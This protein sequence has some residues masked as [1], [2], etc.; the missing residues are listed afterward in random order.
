M[1]KTSKLGVG[2]IAFGQSGRGYTV[3]EVQNDAVILSHPQEEGAKRV[4]IQKI[5]RWEYPHERSDQMNI[6]QQPFQ[7]GD[8]V[9]VFVQDF[10]QPIRGKWC[11]GVILK[12]PIQSPDPQ[13]NMGCWKVTLQEGQTIRYCWHPLYLFSL[14]HEHGEWSL[15]DTSNPDDCK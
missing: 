10:E 11:S 7:V 4:L 12:T 14:N 6:Y 2:A 15:S 9:K 3:S 1:L 13:Q 8:E 5:V